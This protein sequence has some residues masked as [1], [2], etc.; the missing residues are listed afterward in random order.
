MKTRLL[1]LVLV[2]I[3]VL[4]CT[5]TDVGNPHREPNSPTTKGKGVVKLNRLLTNENISLE[6]VV[7]LDPAKLNE[8]S[9]LRSL[10]S[11]RVKNS[12]SL[13]EGGKP[14]LHIIN[15]H[16]QGYAVLSALRSHEPILAYGDNGEIQQENIS[17]S[18]EVLLEGYKK[19]VLQSTN[20]PDSI[21]RKN[22]M[23]WESLQLRQDEL[24]YLPVGNEFIQDHI[25]RLQSEGYQV[26]SYDDLKAGFNPYMSH[27]EIENFV[28]NYPTFGEP[29]SCIFMIAKTE[30]ENDRQE[31]LLKTTWRQEGDFNKY[32]PNNYPVGCVAIAAAQV[33]RYHEYPNSY[34]W[35]LMPTQGITDE[36]SKFVYEVAKGV[37]TSFKPIESLSGPYELVS[38]LTSKGYRSNLSEYTPSGDPERLR[39]DNPII[40]GG[41][42]RGQTTGHAFVADGWSYYKRS[43]RVQVIMITDYAAHD[44]VPSYHD[45]LYEKTVEDLVDSYIHLNLALIGLNNGWFSP[46]GLAGF[47]DRV[48]A[49]TATKP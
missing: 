12:F 36:I 32:T 29:T 16:P 13:N 23:A 45:V 17:S 42:R 1:S 47:N 35:H 25:M 48:K 34:P 21:K 31:P 5:K 28:S 38:Y 14:V 26:Y 2:L 19:S 27:W 24:R 7:G 37:K 33:M 39:F 8:K 3:G 15:Y 20:L 40:L 44:A 46:K 6:Q 11:K 43:T 9:Q 10:S 30:E 4:S 18:L 22:A 41:F 49:I